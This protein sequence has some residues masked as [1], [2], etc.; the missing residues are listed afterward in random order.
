MTKKERYTQSRCKMRGSSSRFC[1]VPQVLVNVCLE[2]PLPK[3][4]PY[5]CKR[6]EVAEARLK[7]G[8]FPLVDTPTLP[9]PPVKFSKCERCEFGCDVGGKV[10]CPLVEGTCVKEECK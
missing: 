2:C 4:R 9:S 5:T 7:Q 8:I 3:C 1:D 10:F 6:Y